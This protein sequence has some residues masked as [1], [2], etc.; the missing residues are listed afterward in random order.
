MITHPITRQYWSRAGT[1]IS[2]L[3][4][5]DDIS[6]T[7]KGTFG[8]LDVDNIT[9]DGAVISSDTLA[10]GFSNNDLSTTGNLIVASDTNGLVLGAGAD[11]TIFSDA[12][13]VVQLLGS[14]GTNNLTLVFDTVDSTSA[15]IQWR[16]A[17]G[18]FF[19][20]GKVSSNNDIQSAGNLI[21]LSDTDGLLLGAGNDVLIYAGDVGE[22]RMLTAATTDNLALHFETTDSNNGS[23]TWLGAT[24]TFDFGTSDISAVNGTLSGTIQAEQLTSTHDA[25]VANILTV[26][27]IYLTDSSTIL[28]QAGVA[29]KSLQ[30]DS[31]GKYVRIGPQNAS[32]CHFDTNTT[33]GFYFFDTILMG[34]AANINFRDAFIGIYSQADSFLDLF[35]DG[36]VRIGDSKTGAPTNYSAF[37]PDGTLTLHGTAQVTKE[38]IIGAGNFHKGSSSPGDGYVN[39]VVYT[40]DFDQTTTQH[41]HYNAIVPTDL[42][43]G[44]DIEVQVDWFFDDVEA[45]KYVT[46]EMQYLTLADGE[47]P[48]TAVTTI[49]QKTVISTGNNDK[50]IHT[51]FGT[52]ITGAVADDT[53]AIRFSRD[54]DAT[55][56][57]DDLGQDARMLV[58]HLHYISDKLGA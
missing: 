22:V 6:T 53:L 2:P 13:G 11:V 41:A 33:K 44:T 28:T 36:A 9:I 25:S 58:V 52:K 23:I 51:T 30:I 38:I 31:S 34:V 48:Y 15:F 27:T 7:G 12:L 29:G 16:G 50:Q 42:A 18:I 24:T 20:G 4:V 39:G 37:G 55:Y 21:A 10:V 32:Y 43:A 19:F 47:D 26:P 3:T 1:V 17:T 54:P 46:W 49:Y 14:T 35:A 8:E 56:D 40:L 5:G 45:G 57:T